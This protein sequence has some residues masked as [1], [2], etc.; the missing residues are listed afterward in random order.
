[1]ND[2]MLSVRRSASRSAA[3]VLLSMTLL[4]S[5]AL[6]ATADT[7]IDISRWQHLHALNWSK[8][9]ADGVTYAFIKAT[10]GRTYTNPYFAGDW[11]ATGSR[12]ILHGAYHFARPSRGTAAAQARHFVSVAGLQAGRGV[13]PPVLDLEVTGRLGVKALRT[14]TATW[15]QNVERLTGRTPI[16]YVSPSFW[17]QHLGNSRAF[18]HYPLW[19][20]HYGVKSPRVPGGWPRWTFWQ[21]T[22]GGHID[23]IAGR[24]DLNRFNGDG[25]QLARMANRR[26]AVSPSTVGTNVPAPPSPT[27]LSMR[28]SK[29]SVY[30]G[31]AV[32]LRGVLKSAKGALV[33]KT[34]TL[35]RQPAGAT[36]A[37]RIGRTTTGKYGRYSFSTTPKRTASYVVKFGGGTA[38]ARA[39]SPA[40]NINLLDAEPT[41][42][43]VAATRT[44]VYPGQDTTITGA[45][46]TAKGSVGGRTVELWQ[47]LEGAVSQTKLRTVTTSATGRYSFTL[48]P[49]VTATYVVKWAGNTRYAAS[50]SIP[51]KITYRRTIPT[52]VTLSSSRT[53]LYPGETVALS[54][55]L[56]S[57]LGTMGPQ[58]VKLYRQDAGE[59]EATVVST[60]TTDAA[61]TFFTAISPTDTAKY[62]VRYPGAATYDPA[63]SSTVG[64]QVLP[65]E[66]TTMTAS[67]RRTTIAQGQGTTFRGRLRTVAGTGVAGMRVVIMRR[68][69]GESTWRRAKVV[70]SSEDGGRWSTLVTPKKTSVFKAVWAGSPRYPGSTSPKIRIVVR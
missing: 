53:G 28:A 34:V 62:T 51:A 31:T 46:F 4:V 63:A 39:T 5:G 57:E 67:A 32:R 33:D 54:G 44:L 38:Y 27:T 40:R 48:H 70:T 10:E 42:L 47:Q 50:S 17:E 22:S 21:R 23:G 18:H 6:A 15:L 29:Y 13:L 66:P 3:A 9:K 55:T 24:V 7:G 26:I 12:G 52:T 25:T 58:T 11:K 35:W 1:M 61:G 68:V 43:G 19:V 30:A 2:A 69:A 37:T 14:W 56:V 49:T 20:A 36:K 8:A 16:I 60:L 45:L 64:I 65:Q 41:T 59:A